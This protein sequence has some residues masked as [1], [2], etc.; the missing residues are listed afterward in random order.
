MLLTTQSQA[1][2]HAPYDERKTEDGSDMLCQQIPAQYSNQTE[3]TLQDTGHSTKNK[4]KNS[5]DRE[6]NLGGS[7]DHIIRQWSLRLAFRFGLGF[8]GWKV[9]SSL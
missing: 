1:E 7:R 6:R 9:T 8:C 5:S 2:S 3:E 4:A